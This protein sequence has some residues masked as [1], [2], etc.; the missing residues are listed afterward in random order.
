MYGFSEVH[1]SD[2]QADRV[3]G[4][5]PLESGKDDGMGRG[6]SNWVGGAGWSGGGGGKEEEV[7]FNVCHGE[8]Q[9]KTKKQKQNVLCK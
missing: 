8:K 4:K 6:G 3:S 1:E 5:I 7:V 2:S 9:Q